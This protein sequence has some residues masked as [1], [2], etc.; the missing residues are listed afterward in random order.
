[1]AL[2]D[3]DDDVLVLILLMLVAERDGTDLLEFA[4]FLQDTLLRL[5]HDFER[6]GRSSRY[7]SGYLFRLLRR[8]LF[9]DEQLGRRDRLKYKIDQVYSHIEGRFDQLGSDLTRRFSDIRNELGSMDGR[10]NDITYE[11]SRAREEASKSI[12]KVSDA[13]KTL[14]WAL[15][16]GVLAGELKAERSIP[17]RIY[18]SDNV[19]SNI[20][21]P[22]IDSI[23][24]VLESL[25]FQKDIELP[26]E[27]GSWWKRIWMKSK[28]L[29]TQEEIQERLIKIE[30]IAE[31]KLLDKPQAEANK[32]HAAAV[33]TIM[34]SLENVNSACVQIGNILL[35]KHTSRNASANKSA[36]S[37]SV[38]VRTL[39][40]IEMRA[41][42]RNQTLLRDPARIIQKL[43]HMCATLHDPSSQIHLPPTVT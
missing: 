7:P 1:M 34:K 10:L 39:N 27:S 29:A 20:T 3:R 22:I 23:I 40:A 19:A 15:S 21:S 32:D 25:A 36:K 43:E 16:V 2:S 14:E 8:S 41:L 18:I 42:E 5:E 33:A 28:E 4:P 37:A 24:S 12:D 38:M 13:L 31:T 35:V 30:R 6:Q 9:S 17:V 26:E 11:N